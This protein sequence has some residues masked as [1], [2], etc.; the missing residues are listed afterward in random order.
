MLILG[1]HWGCAA[2]FQLDLLGCWGWLGAQVRSMVQTA[3]L[4]GTQVAVGKVLHRGLEFRAA[5]APY[6]TNP[7]ASRPEVRGKDMAMLHC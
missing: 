5:T 7:G 6:L 4:L 2:G 3:V 1:H